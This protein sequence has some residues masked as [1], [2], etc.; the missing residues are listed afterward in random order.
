MVGNLKKIDFSQIIIIYLYHI[1]IYH[2]A[3]QFVVIKY[4]LTY[5]YVGTL[6]HSIIY[7]IQLLFTSRCTP[8]E[9]CVA[10][11]LAVG[12]NIGSKT[13]N[14]ENKKC[15]ILWNPSTLIYT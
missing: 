11:F 9:K 7:T 1:V 14:H 8:I 12:K 4:I 15:K 13:H 2:H 10:S 6:L 3:I 5:V